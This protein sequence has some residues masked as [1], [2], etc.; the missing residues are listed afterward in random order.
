MGVGP[1]RWV[2]PGPADSPP[3][4][5]QGHQHQV[6]ALGPC[7]TVA[8]QMA[9]RGT[10]SVRRGGRPPA[11][12]AGRERRK[13]RPLQRWWQQEASRAPASSCLPAY[14]AV[15]ASTVLLPVP[16]QVGEGPACPCPAL[17]PL[18]L[19]QATSC[20]PRSPTAALCEVPLGH[21]WRSR[22]SMETLLSPGHGP[23]R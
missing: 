15:A 10:V 8:R 18:P 23:G 11:G 5:T 3:H 13:P 22:L 12:P 14:L 2:F 7:T 21:G 6:D 9:C 16:S 1:E 4:P 17:L 20:E 19:P